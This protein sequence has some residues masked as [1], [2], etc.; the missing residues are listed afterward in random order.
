VWRR[1]RHSLSGLDDVTTTGDDPRGDGSGRN[2]YVDPDDPYDD[3]ARGD[4]RAPS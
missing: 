4:D 1:R 3:D 2:D